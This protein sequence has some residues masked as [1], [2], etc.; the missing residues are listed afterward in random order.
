M[1]VKCWWKCSQNF[2]RKW[3]KVLDL[4]T[5]TTND[6]HLHLFAILFIF[7]Y[8]NIFFYLSSKNLIDIWS[9][10]TNQVYMFHIANVL[11]QNHCFIF[12][13]LIKDGHSHPWHWIRTLQS[14]S[15]RRRHRI[16]AWRWCRELHGW[17]PRPRAR[18]S[19][20]A[21]G[22]S[23]DRPQGR[24]WRDRHRSRPDEERMEWMDMAFMRWFFW[25]HDN[26]CGNSI[27]NSK[28]YK[29]I[30]PNFTWHEIK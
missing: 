4:A 15:W 26:S 5:R 30:N 20:V 29:N 2:L 1:D 22:S 13:I 16:R 9:T 28:K 10:L 7:M 19:L 14:R 21:T 12:S 25:G 3:K 17:G 8:F 27:Y 11:L 18:G 24:T 6:T 23:R